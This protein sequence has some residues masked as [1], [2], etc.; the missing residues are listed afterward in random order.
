MTDAMSLLTTEG[1]GVDVFNGHEP[2]PRA[3]AAIVVLTLSAAIF[4][5]YVL[6]T[7]HARDMMLPMPAVRS[8]KRRGSSQTR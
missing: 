7:E 3:I 2:S 6:S 5:A 8:R 1:T 4:L